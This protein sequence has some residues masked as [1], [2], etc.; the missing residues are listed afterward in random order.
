MATILDFNSLNKRVSA[1]EESSSGNIQLPSDI[2]CNTLTVSSNRIPNVTIFGD[3]ATYVTGMSEENIIAGANFNPTNVSYQS[4]IWILGG[5]SS[6]DSYTIDDQRG[7]V[8]VGAGYGHSEIYYPNNPIYAIAEQHGHLKCSYDFNLYDA[9][10]DYIIQD[11]YFVG[12]NSGSSN[13]SSSLVIGQINSSDDING[14]TNLPIKAFGDNLTIP[15]YSNVLSYN[16]IN[17]ISFECQFDIYNADGVTI[18]G[19]GT[20]I[21]DELGYGGYNQG[22]FIFG[23]NGKL[24]EENTGTII[25]GNEGKWYSNNNDGTTITGSYGEIKCDTNVGTI[26]TSSYSFM[27]GNSYS[28]SPISNQGIIISGTDS[29]LYIK[30]NK[31]AI[32]SGSIQSYNSLSMSDSYGSKEIYTE[33]TMIVGSSEN[34]KPDSYFRCGLILETPKNLVDSDSNNSVVINS[35]GDRYKVWYPSESLVAAEQHGFLKCANDFSLVDARGYTIIENG[36]FVGNL[37][38]SA[39]IS[40]ESQTPIA[41]VPNTHVLT[42]EEYEEFLEMKD[43]LK[44]W[45]ENIK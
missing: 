37:L 2:T 38:P 19:N 15:Y 44:W 25:L 35:S 34:F 29:S 8:L 1:L 30:D 27:C 42:D 10:G 26:I 32:I 7:I 22:V 23:N 21:N 36:I 4:G 45:K 11:G 33:G 41:S 9:S 43:M 17:L 6:Y 24:L 14:N 16:G 18:C 5:N 12:G 20:R 28:K 3:N 39:T 31:G 13:S 40:N